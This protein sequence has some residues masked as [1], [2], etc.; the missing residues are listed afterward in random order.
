[1]PKQDAAYP[2]SFD[3]IT[4][5]HVNIV[6]RVGDRFDKIYVIVMNNPQ[7]KNIFFFPFRA[8]RNGEERFWAYANVVVD[9]YDGY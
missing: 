5:G 4:N 1:M 8:C 3:P 9:V 6:E 2:G 7:K